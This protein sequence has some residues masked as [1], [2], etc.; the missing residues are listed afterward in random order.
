MKRERERE[1]DDKK[2]AR[3]GGHV[4]CLYR[5]GLRLMFAGAESCACMALEATTAG[6]RRMLSAGKEGGGQSIKSRVLVLSLFCFWHL[7]LFIE[8]RSFVFLC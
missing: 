8:K 6:G 4:G 5:C 2:Q 1:E 3:R 7:L